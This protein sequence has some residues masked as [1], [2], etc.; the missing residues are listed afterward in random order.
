MQLQKHLNVR[1]GF[2]LALNIVGLFLFLEPL[3]ELIGLSFHNRLYSHFTLIPSVSLYFIYRNRRFVF[4]DLAYSYLKGIMVVAAG[5]VFSLIGLSHITDISRNDYLFFVIGGALMWFIG[6][7]ILSYGTSAFRKGI[8]P[9]LFLI[10]M[11]PIPTII[12]N[13]VT[14][15]L[16]IGSTEI[17]Y[18]FFKLTGT[19]I[20]REGFTFSLPRLSIEVSEDCGGIRNCLGLF[21][22]AVLAG[23]LF[24]RTRWKKIFL[25]L[26]VFPISIFRNGI[27]IVTISLLAAHIDPSWLSNGIL[28]G[29]DGGFGGKISF[30]LSLLFLA[31]V[32]WLLRKTEKRNSVEIDPG[33]IDRMDSPRFN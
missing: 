25:M 16:Q 32:L 9:L 14:K 33:I 10:F 28:H 18:V 22:T 11:L 5:V 20:F 29:Q 21:I 13:P 15:F 30:V 19:P 2:F 23:H 4:S 17:S 8:F 6:S 31:P 26:T 24:L 12:L 3:K 1:N 27:R 7:F